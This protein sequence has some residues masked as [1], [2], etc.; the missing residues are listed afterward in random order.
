MKTK[1]MLY[2]QTFVV[3]PTGSVQMVNI[4]LLPLWGLIRNVCSNKFQ[5][6]FYLHHIIFHAM[7]KI[8]TIYFWCL[9]FIFNSIVAIHFVRTTIYIRLNWKKCMTHVSFV[10]FFIILLLWLLLFKTFCG[11]LDNILSTLM[12]ALRITSTIYCLLQIQ[13]TRRFIYI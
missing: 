5:L 2:Q 8:T 9:K 1:N 3:A 11:P 4:H 10:W 7:S 6:S 12:F 13:T